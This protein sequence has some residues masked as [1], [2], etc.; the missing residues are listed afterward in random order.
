MPADIGAKLTF[1]AQVGA[2]LTQIEQ[3]L[4][5]QV[6]IAEALDRARGTSL[7]GHASQIGSD[8]HLLAADAEPVPQ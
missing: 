4:R 3:E 5:N 7:N 2:R 8:Q 6:A 1:V